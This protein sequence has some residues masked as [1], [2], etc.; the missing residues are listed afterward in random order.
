MVKDN[1]LC[2][3]CLL[4]N[5]TVD[6]CFKKFVCDVEGCGKKHTSFIHGIDTV[7]PTS[8][9]TSIVNKSPSNNNVLMPIVPIVVNGSVK[10]YAL[11]DT[12][13]SASLCSSIL[14]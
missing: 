12:G 1:R 11:L 9:V 13:S 10:T 8:H 14:V 4:A 2:E 6:T 5:H 7:N 3:N